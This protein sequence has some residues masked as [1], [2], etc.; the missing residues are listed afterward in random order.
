MLGNLP[1]TAQLLHR[2]QFTNPMSS[3]LS[4]TSL[5][6]LW[7]SFESFSLFLPNYGN[8]SCASWLQCFSILPSPS[9]T[10]WDSESLWS[11]MGFYIFTLN[12]SLSFGSLYMVA[13]ILQKPKPDLK[14]QLRTFFW[15]F[16][17]RQCQRIDSKPHLPQWHRWVAEE[18]GWSKNGFE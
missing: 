7:H 11:N 2:C 15:G 6:C 12:I 17:K 5:L 4:S 1:T 8:D 16:H 3:A 13:E 14:L 18:V 9:E 10:P